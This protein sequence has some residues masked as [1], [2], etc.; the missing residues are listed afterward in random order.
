MNETID[1]PE[2]RCYLLRHLFDKTD[3]NWSNR[4]DVEATLNKLNNCL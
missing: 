1:K 3:E 4:V 2:R